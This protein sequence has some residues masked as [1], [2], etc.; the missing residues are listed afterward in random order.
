M[1]MKRCF[2]I[3]LLIGLLGQ[4]SYAK[5]YRSGNDIVSWGVR[6][7]LNYTSFSDLDFE[8]F[9]E[10]RRSLTGYTGFTAGLQCKLKLPLG[11]AVQPAV[12]YSQSGS[13]IEN[14]EMNVYLKRGSLDVPVDVQWGIRIGPVRPYAMVSPFVGFAL[15]NKFDTNSILGDENL[16]KLDYGV[17]LGAGVE[18]WML[19]VSFRYKWALGTLFD[20]KYENKGT[21][22]LVKDAKFQGFELGLGIL[23]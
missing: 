2:F 16:K 14:P 10:F 3:A 19:Q 20:R 8:S 9:P 23:F 21:V 17:G 15:N 5:G 13:T 12:L 4:V 11:F 6:G 7:G 22:G 1:S 18:L